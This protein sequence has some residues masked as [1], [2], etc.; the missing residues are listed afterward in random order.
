VRTTGNNAYGQLGHKNTK[1]LF[2]FT[3]VKALEKAS[4]RGVQAINVGEDHSACVGGDRTI[5]FW[6]R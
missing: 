5:Y 1:S 2:L 4:V 6:G 3:P